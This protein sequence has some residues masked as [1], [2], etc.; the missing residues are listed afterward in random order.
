MVPSLSSLPRHQTTACQNPAFDWTK[1]PETNP[2]GKMLCGQTAWRKHVVW[3][4]TAL[5]Y[6]AASRLFTQEASTSQVLFNKRERD[7]R[8]AIDLSIWMTESVFFAKTMYGDK[9]AIRIAFL[10][11][12]IGLDRATGRGVEPIWMLPDAPSQIMRVN[13]AAVTWWG[14]AEGAAP[15]SGGYAAERHFFQ[16]N[17]NGNAMTIDQVKA[18]PHERGAE[19][20]GWLSV[21]QAKPMRASVSS[22]SFRH[23]R[24]G[25]SYCAPGY[26]AATSNDIDT[27]FAAGNCKRDVE[28]Y[29]WLRIF[30][31]HWAAVVNE[32]LIAQGTK[33]LPTPK[34]ARAAVPPWCSGS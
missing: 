2:E 6:D 14:S 30:E 22:G 17:Y 19:S 10:A 28:L 13:S 7:V 26:S 24:D 21:A 15:R 16:G 25:A 31:M 8:V 12:G 1:D 33:A 20:G 34:L 9:D 27:K 3:P 23:R 11:A 4:T 29:E 18:A 32:V 5:P